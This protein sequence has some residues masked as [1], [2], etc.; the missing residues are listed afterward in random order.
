MSDWSPWIPPLTLPSQVASIPAGSLLSQVGAY[1]EGFFFFFL[2]ILA[3]AE[4]PFVHL[5]F[6][7]FY[8]IEL[9]PRSPLD[10][11]PY[12]DLW[13]LLLPRGSA[14][15]P[16]PFLHCKEPPLPA[17]PSHLRRSQT[18]TAFLTGHCFRSCLS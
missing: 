16:T 10:L 3:T 8:L 7:S 17:P 15:V 13:W 4:Y 1:F 14:G 12:G 9:R 11:G 18:A 2:E 6:F 5:V